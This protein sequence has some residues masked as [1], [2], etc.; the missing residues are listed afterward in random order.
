[1]TP[2]YRLETKKMKK[3]IALLLSV[4]ATLA[5]AAG[6]EPA[7]EVYRASGYT[8]SARNVEKLKELKA[9]T[10]PLKG[11]TFEQSSSW[12]NHFL[13]RGSFPVYL[14]NKMT[15][16]AY[17]E[18]ALNLELAESGLVLEGVGRVIRAKL[19]EFDFSTSGVGPGK[20]RLEATFSANG[21]QTFSVKTEHEFSSDGSAIDVCRR[22]TMA[23]EYAFTEF[24]Y[25]VYADPRFLELIK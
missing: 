20:W 11:V 4:S 25:T 8:T 17:T 16:S 5:T 22:V 18:A 19:D 13:C 24:L 3:L 12:M 9:K 21:G 7:Y 1:M 6:R 14:P 2:T 10:S 23:L 15:P